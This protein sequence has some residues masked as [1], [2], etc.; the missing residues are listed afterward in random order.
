MNEVCI[1]LEYIFHQ[2]LYKAATARKLKAWLRKQNDGY[3][4]RVKYIVLIEQNF[5]TTNKVFH[6]HCNFAPKL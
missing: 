4:V 5:P 1:S 3:C 6:S 2:N